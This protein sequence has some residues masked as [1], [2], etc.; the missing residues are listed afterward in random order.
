MYLGKYKAWGED[1]LLSAHRAELIHALLN[2]FCI[3]N[4]IVILRASTRDVGSE[5]EVKY[6]KGVVWCYIGFAASNVYWLFSLIDLSDTLMLILNALNISFMLG[7]VVFW[8]I[9]A[10]TKL[11]GRD[12]EIPLWQMLIIIVPFALLLI[13][14]WLSI[15]TGTMFYVEDHDLVQGSH[16]IAII[17]TIGVIFLLITIHAAREAI[18]TTSTSRRRE[19]ITIF[20]FVVMPLLAGV[21]DSILPNMPLMT[22]SVF[23]SILL[24]FTERQ[25]ANI[26]NDSLTGMYNRRHAQDFIEDAV[27]DADK[28]P[29][30][31]ILLDARRFNNIND[32]YGH[33]QG[34][35]VLKIMARAIEDYAK[36]ADC[37][38][39]RWGGDE[40]VLVIEKD[41]V[42]DPG[43]VIQ[44]I[45]RL[46][47][48]GVRVSDVHVEVTFDGG[49]SYCESSKMG[50]DELINAAEDMLEESKKAARAAQ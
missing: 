29:F 4:S 3:L 17:I 16:Y 13:Q 14:T 28:S 7:I 33:L 23:F 6:F 2:F 24:I 44:K 15:H 20:L 50:S 41:K 35:N 45:N 49:Y 18:K 8:A 38:A 37:F 39:A 26:S 9:Y 25:G 30:C 42:E 11:N 46:V 12:N 34:D 10:E 40:F 27:K 1:F 19:Y 5:T 21:T 43:E 36:D 22:P 31:F 32:I 47:W 48:D